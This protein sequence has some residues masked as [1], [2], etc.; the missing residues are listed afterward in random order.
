ME[1]VMRSDPF[2]EEVFARNEATKKPWVNRA[3]VA[4]LDGAASKRPRNGRPLYRGAGYG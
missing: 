4:Y 1:R 3:V 2:V